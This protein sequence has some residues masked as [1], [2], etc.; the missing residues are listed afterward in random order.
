MQETHYWVTILLLCW[1][2][3]FQKQ[4][5]SKNVTYCST[6][7]RDSIA[8]RLCHTPCAFQT[9]QITVFFIG[10]QNS[11]LFFRQKPVRLRIVPPAAL[12]GF[13]QIALFAIGCA[14]VTHELVA[15]TMTTFERDNDHLL[16][17]LIPLYLPTTQSPSRYCKFVKKGVSAFSNRVIASII[18]P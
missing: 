8:L 10:A 15:A 2:S 12:T 11:F 6:A 5:S 14:P 13:A 3:N 9:A 7:R 18:S 17:I 4:D 1:Q 16:M